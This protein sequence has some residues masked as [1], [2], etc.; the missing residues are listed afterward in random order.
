M[1]RSGRTGLETDA[2]IIDHAVIHE[3]VMLLVGDGRR[4]NQLTYLACRRCPR[5]LR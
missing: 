1:D 5:F 2:G 3:S 4:W